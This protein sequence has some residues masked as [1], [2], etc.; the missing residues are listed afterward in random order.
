VRAISADLLDGSD[1]S[2]KLGTLRDVTH[3]V[4]GAYIEKETPTERSAVNVAL[5]R[6]LLDVV[7]ESSPNLL[8]FTLYQGGKAYGADLGPFRTPAREDDDRQGNFVRYAIADDTVSQLCA[9]VCRK[10]EKDALARIAAFKGVPLVSSNR[11]S[12]RS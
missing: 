8:H 7:E 9:L 4:F 1:V 10:I 6:N 11:N 2:K 5:L 3:V 12:E